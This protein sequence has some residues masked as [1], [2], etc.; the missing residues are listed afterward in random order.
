MAGLL[1]PAR[2]RVSAERYRRFTLFATWAL[3]FIILTGAAVRLT[4]SGLGCPDWPNCEENQLIA[5]LE[6]HPMVEFINRVIT[7]LVSLAVALTVLGSL[8]RRPRRRDLIWWSFGLVAGVAVQVG[9]GALVVESHLAPRL[10]MAHFLVSI[11]LL[12]NAV[13]LHWLAGSPDERPASQ[14]RRAQGQPIWLRLGSYLTMA[15]VS[16]AIVTGTLLTGAG[17]HGGDEEAV[18]FSLHIPTLARIHGSA[19]ILTFAGALALW[20]YLERG[21]RKSRQRELNPAV[22]LA[23]V[24]VLI[25][26]FQTFVGYAQYF[27]EVPALLVG[28]HIA[29]SV[30]IWVV[31]LQLFLAMRS[32]AHTKKTQIRPMRVGD[33][34]TNAEALLRRHVERE[35]S[36]L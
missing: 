15:A 13:I 9:L 29:G 34:T 35:E 17:P 33:R 16:A 12:A 22:R 24:F 30:T 25:L 26:G 27:N 32:G 1:Q 21:W 10:V 7:G 28:F 4:G 23:R 19:M 2:L 6:Y 18:R 5:D 11:V 20:A 14:T 31:S 36:P 3:A 8:L